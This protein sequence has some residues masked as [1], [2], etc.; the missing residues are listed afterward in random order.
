MT[1]DEKLEADREFKSLNRYQNAEKAAEIF[2]NDDLVVKPGTFHYSTYGFTVLEWII[3]K[4]GE[5]S[6]AKQLEFFCKE[7]GIKNTTVDVPE[8]IIPNRARGY[9]IKVGKSKENIAGENFI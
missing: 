7:V 5:K 3:E 1:D 6:F 2:K 9:H 8:A 4:L